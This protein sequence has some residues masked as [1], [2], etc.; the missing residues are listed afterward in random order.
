MVLIGRHQKKFIEKVRKY[1]VPKCE[2]KYK[3]V[4]ILFQKMRAYHYFFFH[5]VFYQIYQH[6]IRYNYVN[7]E[8]EDP[9]QSQK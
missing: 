4:F 9:F 7:F 2:A 8:G 5:S 1:V 3:F 6:V